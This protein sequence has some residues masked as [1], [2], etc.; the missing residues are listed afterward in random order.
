M[1]SGIEHGFSG[2]SFLVAAR[3]YG[4]C[5]YFE[6]CAPCLVISIQHGLSS[7]CHAGS[8]FRLLQEDNSIANQVWGITPRPGHS[9]P[10]QVTRRVTMVAS[11]HKPLLPDESQQCTLSLSDVAAQPSNSPAPKV[12]HEKLAAA[13]SPAVNQVSALLLYLR[14]ARWGLLKLLKLT[15]LVPVSMGACLYGSLQHL[16]EC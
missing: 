14:H 15:S 4:T 13:G 3:A 12:K 7:G 8:H 5:E 10:V 1:Q 16:N 11:A 9:T 6:Q 2:G